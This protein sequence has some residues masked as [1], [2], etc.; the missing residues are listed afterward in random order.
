MGVSVSRRPEGV[1]SA[2]AGCAVAA[3]GSSS[4]SGEVKEERDTEEVENAPS[5]AQLLLPPGLGGESPSELPAA[6]AKFSLSYSTEALNGWVKQPSPCCGAASVAGAWN[7]VLGVP[8]SH[9]AAL[10][11]TDV[12]RIYA[13]LVAE[14]LR[15]KQASFERLLGAPL[16]LLLQELAALLEEKATP[17]GTKS[18]P[19]KKDMLAAVQLLAREGS[20]REA[21]REEVAARE[22]AAPEAADPSACAT[23]MDE[24]VLPTLARG[25]P[26]QAHAKLHSLF[27][28][29]AA[30]QGV[31]A[32]GADEAAG[33]DEGADGADRGAD[34]G[35]DG[36]AAGG[37]EPEGD[38][39]QEN[40]RPVSTNAA[41]P[42]HSGQALAEGSLAAGATGGAAAAEPKGGVL[43]DFDFGK[44]ASKPKP[45]AKA[46][47][48]KASA[49]GALKPASK[50]GPSSRGGSRAASPSP[51]GEEGDALDEWYAEGGA[52]WL[53]PQWSWRKDLGDILHTLNG[54]E[55][56]R[57]PQKPNTALIGNWGIFAAV[58][59][60]QESLAGAQGGSCAQGDDCARAERVA[61]AALRTL[62]GRLEAK[63]LMGRGAVG[64]ANGA[65]EYVSLRP[66]D[67]PEERE[68]AWAAL[69]TAFL[70]PRA[71]LLF[72]LRNHY[73]LIFALRE[74]EEAVS[75]DESGA[76][77]EGAT[78]G[79][80]GE[81]APPRLR[82]R[83]VRQILTARK[84]Q[85]PTVWM[86]F[87]EVAQIMI[88]WEG[89]KIMQISL[90][91]AQ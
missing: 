64:K 6:V 68:R 53:G 33:A 15:Q 62:T 74:W 2:A 37:A 57:H 54:L 24:M 32:D 66:S 28:A 67:G 45:K 83:C 79:A 47:R 3:A 11:H 89:Y 34:G 43:L 52:A 17:L 56:L 80:V 60:L 86:D 29:E 51:D 76:T 58:R 44:P 88:G 5:L 55:R 73:A 41:K 71:A 22:G 61:A 36:G 23:P 30:S 39:D 75:H 31:A 91:D 63:A 69:R 82:Y 20:A 25:P 21:A 18:A 27:E 1:R 84:G 9:G 40:Q 16:D 35:A 90:H 49:K 26:L 78:D 10:D 13:G 7:A 14:Q 77:A 85:R 8:R 59:S 70:S 48:A 38:S 4:S 12:L 87:E 50:P 19:A 42:E 72:H 65:A 81:G 46:K